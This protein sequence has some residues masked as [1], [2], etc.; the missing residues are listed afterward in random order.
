MVNVYAE[1]I[2]FFNF[3]IHHRVSGDISDHLKRG[4][5]NLP[6]N[7]QHLLEKVVVILRILAVF[8]HNLACKAGQS[9]LT[10]HSVK[11]DFSL[12]KKN[13]DLNYFHSF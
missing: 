6:K 11:Y 7:Y 2:F 10:H 12:D 8:E 4:D 5:K 1:Q 13:S 3:A 9:V